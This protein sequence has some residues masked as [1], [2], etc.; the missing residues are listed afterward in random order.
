MDFNGFYHPYPLSEDEPSISAEFSGQVP[1]DFRANGQLDDLLSGYNM[2]FSDNTN[3]HQML[4]LP[5]WEMFDE[6][7][8]ERDDTPWHAD[9]SHSGAVAGKDLLEAEDTPSHANTSR[10]NAAHSK[11]LV[12]AEDTPLHI[13]ASHL[14]AAPRED[15][16][17]AKPAATTRSKKR[18]SGTAPTASTPVKKQKITETET[19][20]KHIK[21]RMKGKKG[22]NEGFIPNWDAMEVYGERTLRFKIGITK[23]KKFLTDEGVD[24]AKEFPTVNMVYDGKKMTRGNAMVKKARELHQARID[25]KLAI[26]HGANTP[27]NTRRNPPTTGGD[28]IEPEHLGET[29]HDEHAKGHDIVKDVAQS[30]TGEDDRNSELDGV[31]E[32]DHEHVPEVAG[33]PERVVVSSTRQAL[34]ALKKA[35]LKSGSFSPDLV[36]DGLD[37]PLISLRAQEIVPR[38]VIW[39]EKNRVFRN[40]AGDDSPYLRSTDLTEEGLAT[41]KKDLEDLASELGILVSGDEDEETMAKVKSL[42]VEEFSV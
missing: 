30:E 5:G 27:G 32:S 28:D 22:V 15:L 12:E 36:L 11:D 39:Q 14:N 10:S 9:A 6:P 21:P 18:A 42:A 1:E 33:T 17:Q 35:T 25:R 31:C 4:T 34:R 26:I 7:D 16:V 24:V 37:R 19:D 3:R 23:L 8:Q 13:K 38:L 2:S 20:R 29:E 40:K 41:Y